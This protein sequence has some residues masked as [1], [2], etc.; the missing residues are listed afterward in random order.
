M[1]RTVILSLCALTA[2]GP[3]YVSPEL[4]DAE[5]A[6]SWSDGSVEADLILRAANE[7]S[8]DELDV[9]ASLDRRAAEG[10]VAARPFATLDTLDAV[11]YVGTSALDK[12]Y[13][14]GV[15]RFGTEGLT[16]EEEDALILHIANSATFEVLDDDVG[17]DRRAAAGIVEQR[18]FATVSDLDAVP[19]VGPS[20]LADLLGYGIATVWAV[21][22]AG[23]ITNDAGG[24]YTDLGEALRRSPE[25]STVMLCAGVFE[26]DDALLNHSLVVQ[27]QG[28][29]LTEVRSAGG[30]AITV[31]GWPH[32]L[33]LRD[34][35]VSQ[36]MPAEAVAT[37][38]ASA[39]ASIVIDRVRFR[40]NTVG[41]YLYSALRADVLDSEFVDNVEVG[42]SAF[43][44]I[45]VVSE[46][47][48]YEGNGMAVELLTVD[49]ASFTGDSFHRNHGPDGAIYSK[50]YYR[51]DDWFLLFD[52]VDFG[53]GDTDNEAHD[54][55]L[56]YETERYRLDAYGAGTSVVCNHKTCRSY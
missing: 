32:V 34:L 55:T 37:V 56:A 29:D 21:C 54:L 19:Y 12:L 2:C 26:V 40:D 24:T 39:S 13:D 18:P 3:Q 25:G 20:A 38:T 22:P 16:P 43:S 53:M 10:I 31:S 1:N 27:G 28:W 47:T 5:A 51:P 33:E 23:H 9:D 52:D 11:P 50:A 15:E 49:E 45:E 7:L 41:L 14:I 42:L 6:R 17:L 48:R 8:F 4:A 30:Q 44:A 36:G 46:G 35:T